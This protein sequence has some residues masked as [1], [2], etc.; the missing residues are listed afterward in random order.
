MKKKTKDSPGMIRVARLEITGLTKEQ[1]DRWLELSRQCQQIV[2][3][4]W[5]TWLVWHVK[6]G[7]EAMLR[8]HFESDKKWREADPK[9]RGERQ[10]WPVNAVDSECSKAIYAE[11]SRK[12]TTVHAR[13]QVLMIQ[14]ETNKIK[15]LKACYG[16]LPGWVAIL[17]CQ[18]SIPSSVRVIPIR[19]DKA[20]CEIEPP[21]DA[22]Q[23]FKLHIRLSR[24][25]IA[26]KKSCPSIAETIELYTKSRNA[27]SAAETMKKIT[28]GEYEFCGSNIM[29]DNGKW[30]ALVCY[31]QPLPKVDALD[32][33]R[34]AYLRPSRMWP[35]SLL[36]PGAN[37][38]RHPGGSGYIVAV[39]RKQVA[40]TRA[41]YRAG[42]RHAGT[43]RRGHG[44]NRSM[45]KLWKM[46]DHWNDFVRTMNYTAA[47]D[48]L[49]QCKQ[50]NCGKI[51]YLQPT[52]RVY[53][54]SFLVN[55][56]KRDDV[57]DSS[58]W[59]FHQMGNRLKTLAAQYGVTVE[60]VKS[61]ERKETAKAA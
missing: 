32:E 20:N 29:F 48:I 8:K 49:E 5:R 52:G 10:K 18:Q 56:G 22:K 59:D 17:F 14:A 9:K 50:R 33:S 46:T 47:K 25:P 1:R 44:R 12:F 42:Y 57:R 24:I 26:G 16:N 6:N 40:G 36:F 19:F 39:K 61:G 35:W 4:I 43:S 34:V 41:T 23:N 45:G 3:C 7:S 37:R 58:G 55:V 51:V 60:I 2:N 38:M 21:A 30:F 53:D 28:R 27:K 13:V 15:K 31:R 54:K 11:I